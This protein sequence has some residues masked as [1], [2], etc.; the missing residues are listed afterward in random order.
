M[1][2]I[3]VGNVGGAHCPSSVVSSGYEGTLT[4]VHRPANPQTALLILTGRETKWKDS[5]LPQAK[6]LNLEMRFF[7]TFQSTL[8]DDLHIMT[9]TI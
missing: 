7:L 3:L 6:C 2:E 9:I 8:G 1:F 5:K 4:R